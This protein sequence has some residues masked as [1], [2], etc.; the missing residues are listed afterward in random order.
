MNEEPV[1]VL[2]SFGVRMGSS[3]GVNTSIDDKEVMDVHRPW[4]MT[5]HDSQNN[6]LETGPPSHFGRGNYQAQAS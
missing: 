6:W 3:D 1:K 4:Q 5:Q 2:F